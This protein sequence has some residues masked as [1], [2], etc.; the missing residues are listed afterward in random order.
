MHGAPE[1][2]A[3]DRARSILCIFTCV[4]GRKGKLEIFDENWRTDDVSLMSI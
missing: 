2:S 3:D 4:Q 1:C